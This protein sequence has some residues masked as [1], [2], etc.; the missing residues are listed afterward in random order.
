M[1]QHISAGPVYVPVRGS[2][3]CNYVCVLG[4]RDLA[5]TAPYLA[6]INITELI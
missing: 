5:Q 6:Q 3:V 1:A 2:S 4:T